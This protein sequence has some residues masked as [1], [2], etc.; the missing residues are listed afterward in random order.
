MNE[1]FEVFVKKDIFTRKLIVKDREIRIGKVYTNNVALDVDFDSFKL[2]EL[3]QN[4]LRLYPN[5]RFEII[6]K[7]DGFEKKLSEIISFV[8]VRNFIEIKKDIRII[9]SVGDYELFIA[10][11]VIKESHISYVPDKFKESIIV[12]E[13]HWLFKSF[14]AYVNPCILFYGDFDYKGSKEPVYSIANQ[15]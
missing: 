3:E 14:N 12:R 13:K 5:N 4:C 9:V 7:K 15:G 1:G 2:L 6:L 11:I 10:P 8:E